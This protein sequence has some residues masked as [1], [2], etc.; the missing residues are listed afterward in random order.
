MPCCRVLV[1]HQSRW[2]RVRRQGACAVAS[3]KEPF[4]L[5]P[6]CPARRNSLVVPPR[7]SPVRLYSSVVGTEREFSVTWSLPQERTWRFSLSLWIPRSLY[8]HH[9]LRCRHVLGRNE[10]CASHAFIAKI[11]QFPSKVNPGQ[12][13]TVLVESLTHLPPASLPSLTLAVHQNLC[14]PSRSASVFWPSSCPSL[15][16]TVTA[17][18]TFSGGRR[19][20]W[21]AKCLF[22]NKKKKS[23]PLE[24]VISL[25]TTCLSWSFC[26]VC[27]CGFSD[28][29][30]WP[31]VNIDAD[32]LRCD[33]ARIMPRCSFVVIPV[34]RFVL[35]P[36]D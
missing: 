19:E 7:S 17:R 20:S 2:K 26:V 29:S 3:K 22:I 31:L 23:R 1:R 34:G 25:Y 4:L 6:D 30:M 28:A 24:L 21:W 12:N 11:K 33:C 15:L 8:Y 5:V 9:L 18:T 35:L 32:V 10:T 14:R 36:F 27:G 16:A 13:R